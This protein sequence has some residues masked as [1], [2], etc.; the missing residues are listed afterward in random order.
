MTIGRLTLTEDWEAQSRADDRGRSITLS[1]QEVA[2]VLGSQAAARDRVEN[3]LAYVGAVVPVAFA[4]KSN[5]AGWY[6]VAD[7]SATESTWNDSTTIRWSL[8][9]TRVG[10]ESGIEVES[11]LVGG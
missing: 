8:T 11:R 2:A 7:P 1:G 9:L 6:E 10:G 4:A 3:L 5:L